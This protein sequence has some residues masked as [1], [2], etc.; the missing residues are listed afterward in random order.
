MV[1]TVIITIRSNDGYTRV[2][3]S[4]SSV[5]S[6]GDVAVVPHADVPRLLAE[7]LR[8]VTTKAPELAT[9]DVGLLNAWITSCS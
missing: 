2:A 6:T 5:A 7:C 3:R 4:D 9:V 8:A 1:N